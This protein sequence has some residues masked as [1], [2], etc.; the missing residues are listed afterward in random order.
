MK[1]DKKEIR[2]D[3]VCSFVLRYEQLGG[4]FSFA[5]T[6]PA[7][8][9]DTFYA[10]ATLDLLKIQYSNDKTKEYIRSI[11]KIGGVKHLFQ[12][13]F[14]SKRYNIEI[15]WL[16]NAIENFPF[17]T[18]HDPESIYYASKIAE[19]LGND[20]ITIKL[21]QN[22]KKISMKEHL[23]SELCWKAISHKKLGVQFDKEKVAEKIKQFQG[24]DGGFSFTEKGAPSFIEETYL[25]MEALSELSHKPNN[26]E[27]CISFVQSCRA[28][29]GGY[30]RQITTVPSLEATY[31]A[32]AILKILKY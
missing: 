7:T 26:T 15:A 3:E 28:N 24:Y 9:E 25:A 2:K 21:I 31:Y 5:R 20:E 30:G 29:D 32:V 16:Y 19:L 11:E 23:L 14:I 18:I 12:I 4:G 1:A 8:L 13:L 10:L 17:E 27:A 22:L 6:T